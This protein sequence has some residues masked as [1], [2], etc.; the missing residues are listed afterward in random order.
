MTDSEN[1]SDV[2]QVKEMNKLLPAVR[3]LAPS[4]FFRVPQTRD[5]V[6]LGSL[7]Q[8]LARHNVVIFGERHHQ[9]SVLK[10]QLA[11]LAEFASVK[12]DVTLV[13][14]MVNFEQQKFLDRFSSDQSYTPSD[15]QKD[16]DS[17][18]KEAFN[19]EQHY[20]YLLLLARELGC[21]IRAGFLPKQH[22]RLAMSSNLSELKKA[23][24]E[25]YPEFDLDRYFIQ[26]PGSDE[27]Y[28]YFESMIHGLSRRPRPED[29]G[30]LITGQ[31]KR[32]FPA[33]IIKDASMA[34]AIDRVLK[35]AKD[36]AEVGVFGICGNGHSDYQY[37]VPERLDKGL[38]KPDGKAFVI[39][40]RSTA[41][42]T[43]EDKEGVD[44][45][46]EVADALYV[47]ESTPDEE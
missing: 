8:Q 46:E 9:P 22:A 39:T 42:V 1:A 28:A 3:K 36:P 17:T 2:S 33:Q 41:E 4:V 24:S 35:E 10:A 7:S 38:S 21:K 40:S 31:M 25:S 29:I 18:G 5:P 19:L 26:K 6:S 34:S 30:S 23:V 11:C 15:L 27:H 14:E 44:W 13:L 43:S 45:D 12:K 20:G 37:G 32:I 47:Y 16:Y